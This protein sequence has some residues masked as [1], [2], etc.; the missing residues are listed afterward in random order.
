MMN[1]DNENIYF[2]KKELSYVIIS[3]IKTVVNIYFMEI[4]C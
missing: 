1:Y 4:K 2:D 3:K